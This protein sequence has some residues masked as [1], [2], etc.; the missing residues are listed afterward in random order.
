MSAK[1]TKL[2][3]VERGLYHDYLET[4]NGHNDHCQPVN[5]ID[6]QGEEQWVGMYR[7]TQTRLRR[8]NDAK[9]ASQAS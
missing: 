4:V 2:T 3:G 9:S 5:H 1:K 8:E 6:P 7:A